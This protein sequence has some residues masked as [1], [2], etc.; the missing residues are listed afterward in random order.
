MADR[1]RQKNLLIALGIFAIAL[2]LLWLIAR[3]LSD[4][5][6]D[7]AFFESLP[8][9]RPAVMA[10]RGGAMLWPENTITAFRAARN[11][12]VDAIELD[13][14]A[15]SDGT[16]V[17]IH[18]G[19]VDRTTE[20]QGQV[21]S[22][23]VEELQSLDAGYSFEPLEGS[24]STPYRG[25]GLRIPTLEQ[26]FEEF[27]E[28]PLVIEIK[29]QEQELVEE[30][31]ALITEYDREPLTL[32]ASVFG[33][34]QDAVRE[35]VPSLATSAVQGEVIPFFIANRLFVPGVYTPVSEAFL[36]PTSAGPLPVT[37]R[38]FIENAQNRNL[39]V[40]AFTVNDSDTMEILIDREIDAVITGRPDLM[41]ELLGEL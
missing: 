8:Q 13:V 33:E 19:S 4:P 36:V 2:F 31:A 39:Y 18:D 7:N 30:V 32:V 11:M 10:H 3:I 6:P 27:P 1:K 28:M 34:V 14:R 25:M 35:A 20:E 37:T 5:A 21:D 24:T 9:D 15:A 23:T 22:K 40:G 17:V 29:A 41:L 38:G 26:V 16:P 12:G